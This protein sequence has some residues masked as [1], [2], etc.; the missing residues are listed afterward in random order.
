[1]L[2]TDTLCIILLI[3]T[4]GIIY[5]LSQRPQHSP[6]EITINGHTISIKGSCYHTTSS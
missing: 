3:L 6:C 1:M 5:N 4:L 2:N